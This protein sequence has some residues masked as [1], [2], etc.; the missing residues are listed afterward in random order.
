MSIK[1]L[2]ICVIIIN[3]KILLIFNLNAQIWV[4]RTNAQTLIEKNVKFGS[5]LFK[6]WQVKDRV[7]AGFKD[8]VLNS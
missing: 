4:Y 2:L 7:L 3:G 1:S 5:S 8:G 6:G